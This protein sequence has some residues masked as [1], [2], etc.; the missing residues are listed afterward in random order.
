MFLSITTGSKVTTMPKTAHN[1]ELREY[2][3]EI[4]RFLYNRQYDVYVILS[5]A[6]SFQSGILLVDLGF[7]EYVIMT[8]IYH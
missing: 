5:R 1:R 2:A 7:H 6:F 8:H 3:F 4:G